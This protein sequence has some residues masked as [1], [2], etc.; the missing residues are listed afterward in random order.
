MLHDSEMRKSVAGLYKVTDIRLHIK[1]TVF[2]K[3]LRCA[4][5]ILTFK[6]NFV[7]EFTVSQPNYQDNFRDISYDCCCNQ[8]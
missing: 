2:S 4:S 8:F 1:L 7:G 5:S 3:N 6:V